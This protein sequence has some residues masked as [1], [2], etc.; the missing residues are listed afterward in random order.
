MTQP[1]ATAFV[2][3]ALALVPGCF[4]DP[5]YGAGVEQSVPDPSLI[6]GDGGATPRGAGGTDDG[7]PNDG[8][9][10]SMEAPLG[11]IGCG[12]SGGSTGTGQ[13]SGFPRLISLSSQVQSALPGDTVPAPPAFRLEDGDGK[14]MAN[15]AVMI[16]LD[17]DEGTFSLGGPQLTATTVTTDGSGEV[18]LSG[19]TLPK[20][21]GSSTLEVDVPGMPAVGTLT[22]AAAGASEFEVRIEPVG[23]MSASQLAVFERARRRWE[24]VI[25]NALTPLPTS[26]ADLAAGCGIPSGVSSTAIATTG[27]V[28]FAEITPID[29]P[30]SILGSAG[31]CLIRS[32]SRSPVAGMMRFDSADVANLQSA[33]SFEAV[34]LHE[35]GHV[36]GV[37]TLW[38]LEGFLQNPSL[39][40][41]PGA[42]THHDGPLTLA[43][44]NAIGGQ[45]FTSGT[46]VP[47]ENSAIPGSGDGHWRE[48][49]ARN[50][51]MTPYLDS[52]S[53]PLSRLTVGSID[54]FPYYQANQLAADAFT[55]APNLSNPGG[56]TSTPK[57][58]NV[59]RP[60]AGFAPA[61]TQPAF[62]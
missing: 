49:V 57:A 6:G 41:S 35:M 23:T 54:D 4:L 61:G 48:S 43:A 26:L 8:A 53:A 31:P 60:V 13:P 17:T 9:S 15:T 42:D 18:H 51:L 47:V 36:L 62:P 29:G 32:G 19:W 12:G 14:P 30:G 56:P 28:I 27:V 7:L 59:L 52:A 16:T 20:L 50:E 25:V 1:S 2:P 46:R 55:L 33:G 37:G 58:C 39:P 3:L 24:A 22:F 45:V 40:S 21:S 38:G 5:G 11:C 10:S 34:I 44:F